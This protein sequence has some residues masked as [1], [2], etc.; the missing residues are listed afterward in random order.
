MSTKQPIVTPFPALSPDEP[1]PT[2]EINPSEPLPEESPTSTETPPPPPP[3][4]EV[5]PHCTPEQIG[6]GT[7]Q[8][9]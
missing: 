6:N 9:D 1:T 4:P 5:Q 8:R 7:C 2:V 3:E